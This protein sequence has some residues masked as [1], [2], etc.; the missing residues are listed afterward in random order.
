MSLAVG[1]GAGVHGCRSV[2]VDL[3]RAVLQ[4]QAHGGGHF[5]VGRDADTELLRFTSGASTFL[6][7]AEVV[8]ACGR[9]G[10]VEGLGVTTRVVVAA[11]R[12]GDRLVEIRKEVDS[13]DLGR[14]DAGHVGSDVEHALD[15]L[16]RLGTTSAAVGTDRGVVRQRRRGSELHGRYVVDTDRHHLRQH[17]QDRS[18][19]RIGAGGRG[20]VCLQSDDSTVRRH[21]ELGL[22]HVVPA[23]NERD[24]VL[25]PCLGP[26]DRRTERHRRLGGDRV[27][28][29]HG[30]FRAEPASHPRTHD[31]QLVGVETEESRERAMRSMRRLMRDPTRQR[32]VT[33][34]Y[35]Q[36][37]VRLHRHAGKTLTDHRHLGDHVCAVEWVFVVSMG[38]S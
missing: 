20:D 2:V 10:S 37:A 27:L 17:R 16:G 24:H 4:V 26:L 3:A 13:P 21:A 8:V 30:S 36:Q 12:R 1:A 34:G 19:R 14:I 35:R 7:G 31:T 22:H 38:S 6:F 23:V 18:D 29:V 32:T 28:G 11:C 33:V 25:C 5:D 15:Q 9:Q